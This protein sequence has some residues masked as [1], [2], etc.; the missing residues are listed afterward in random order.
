[1]CLLY[2][3]VSVFRQ[4]GKSVSR[5]YSNSCWMKVFRSSEWLRISSWNSYADTKIPTEHFYLKQTLL[6]KN[7]K[8]SEY[9]HFSGSGMRINKL[10][11]LYDHSAKK[12]LTCFR[13]PDKA[14]SWNF[15]WWYCLTKKI[16]W[17]RHPSHY[18]FWKNFLVCKLLTNRFT[19]RYRYFIVSIYWG[20]QS[21]L[22][23]LK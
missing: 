1:M 2:I 5:E 9:G 17:W 20:I 12:S 23:H 16:K 10:L 19:R 7:E 3:T 21:L 4:W 22:K 18:I 11:F 13:F 8:N 15:N 14:C 6:Q